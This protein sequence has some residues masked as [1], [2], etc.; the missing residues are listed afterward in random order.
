MLPTSINTWAKH[1]L[2][3]LYLRVGDPI[4]PYGW[5]EADK[6]VYVVLQLVQDALNFKKLLESSPGL[7]KDLESVLEDLKNE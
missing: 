4:T 2:R 7:Q 1:A 3:D 6:E 5:L